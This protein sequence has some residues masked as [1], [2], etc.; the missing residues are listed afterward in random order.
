MTKAELVAKIAEEASISQAQANKA[1]HSF[2]QNV[3]REVKTNG[4]ISVAGLGSF[5]ISKRAARTGINPRTREPIKIAAC[6]SVRFKC[7]KALKDL[8]NE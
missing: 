2:V 6:N 3:C 4:G 5:S 7:A 8:V 1:L